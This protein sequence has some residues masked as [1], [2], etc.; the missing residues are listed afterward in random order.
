MK[1]HTMATTEVEIKATR[2]AS[3]SKWAGIE[4]D[5]KQLPRGHAL[6][7][8]ELGVDEKHSL[9]SIRYSLRQYLKKV[10]I[11]DQYS[12]GYCDEGLAVTRK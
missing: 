8:S 5:L 12:I 4:R 7:I 1:F 9:N 3:Q 11:L 10:G 2:Q 6:I